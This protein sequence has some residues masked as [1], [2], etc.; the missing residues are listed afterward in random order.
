MPLTDPTDVSAPPAAVPTPLGT[1]PPLVRPADLPRD[2]D[3]DGHER[4]Q[5]EHHEAIVHGNLDHPVVRVDLAVQCKGVLVCCGSRKPVRAGAQQLV[6]LQQSESEG[7]Q[8]HAY[9]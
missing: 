2:R 1:V 9:R 4:E 7:Q 6:A 5:G 3:V 8:G